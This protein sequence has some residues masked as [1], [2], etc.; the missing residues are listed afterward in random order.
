MKI[1]DFING[2]VTYSKQGQ[3][4][5]ID[6]GMRLLAQLRGWGTF[7]KMFST[8][9]D[10]AKFQDEVGQFVADAINEKIEREKI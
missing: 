7:T 9:K 8:G 4:L 6:N 2:K 1:T 5:W 3:Y 10:A